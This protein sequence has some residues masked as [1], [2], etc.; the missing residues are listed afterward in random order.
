[1]MKRARWGPT[2]GL[3]L[4]LAACRPPEG[5]PTVADRPADYGTAVQRLV[6][7]HTAILARQVPSE[8]AEQ[9]IQDQDQ[10]VNWLPWLAADSDLAEEPWNRVAATADALTDWA[11]GLDG[12]SAHTRL[13]RHRAQAY[14]WQ[15]ALDELYRIGLLLEDSP[16]G[17]EPAAPEHTTFREAHGELPR[18]P[19]DPS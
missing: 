12:V 13:E 9:V 1:M 19:E 5:L 3:I 14:D 15:A 16:P 8:A 6:E 7:L 11:D 4:L 10:I 18:G 2:C 17:S